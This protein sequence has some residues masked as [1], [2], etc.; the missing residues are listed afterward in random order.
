MGDFRPNQGLF[1]W[2]YP[3]KHN[4][5]RVTRLVD[6]LETV[7][8]SRSLRDVLVELKGVANQAGL[9][10]GANKILQPLQAIVEGL[11]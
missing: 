8:G 2:E 7:A 9:G 5:L 4:R 6:S 1:R 10:V 3:E 11:A